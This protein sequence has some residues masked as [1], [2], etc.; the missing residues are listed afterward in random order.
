M[1][2]NEWSHVGSAFKATGKFLGGTDDKMQQLPTHSGQQQEFQNNLLQQLSG[3]D[4]NLNNNPLYQQGGDYYSGL[5]QDT[6]QSYDKFK[7]PMMREFNE[8]IMPGIG[9]QFAGVGGL[10]SSG[11]QQ[12]ATGAGAGLSER[13]GALRAGMQ[14][15][16]AQGALQ[17]AQAPSQQAQ[18]WANTAMDSPFAYQ[19][20]AG[21]QGQLGNIVKLLAAFL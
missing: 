14:E 1:R 13:L 15:R 4:Y 7:A 21:K 11:F 19:N 10:S 3:Q 20:K 17:Y 6:P 8:E 12:A 16:G 18:S 5:M 9:E 2:K